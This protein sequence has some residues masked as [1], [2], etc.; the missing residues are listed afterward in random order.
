MQNQMIVPF[1]PWVLR[2]NTLQT[3]VFLI[4]QYVVL[5]FPFFEIVSKFTSSSN[6]SV[7]FKFLLDVDSYFSSRIERF[8]IP[9]LIES[10]PKKY[11][12]QDE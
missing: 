3:S 8:K 10:F 9:C 5:R 12:Y 2:K 11:I 4:T 1:S 7:H 6:W